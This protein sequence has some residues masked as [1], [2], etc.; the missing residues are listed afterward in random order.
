MG[1]KKVATF[2][3]RSMLARQGV[4]QVCLLGEE[5]GYARRDSG[6]FYTAHIVG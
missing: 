4:A 5:I 6:T 2:F 1:V 3:R